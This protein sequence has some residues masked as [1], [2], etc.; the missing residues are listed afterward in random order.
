MA[1]AG[2]VPVTLDKV[3]QCLWFRGRSW[4]FPNFGTRAFIVVS[5][6]SGTKYFG[7]LISIILRIETPDI[8]YH[9]SLQMI[10]LIACD[11]LMI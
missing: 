11:I 8:D 10:N 4:L 5:L 7:D 2:D 1:K 6:D 3:G 9:R